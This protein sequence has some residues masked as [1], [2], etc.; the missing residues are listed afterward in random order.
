VILPEETDILEKT[1]FSANLSTTGLGLKLDLSCEMRTTY[2]LSHSS[3]FVSYPYIINYIYV[4]VL[5]IS[6][7][8]NSSVASGCVTYW[9]YR[10]RVET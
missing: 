6:D 9:L 4:G 3:K 5:Y 8:Q 10:L 7:I 2:C 1:F